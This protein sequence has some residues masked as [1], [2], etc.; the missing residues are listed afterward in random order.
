MAKNS[1]KISTDL[2]SA[3]DILTRLRAGCSGVRIPVGV[4]RFPLSK[5]V[6]TGSEAHPV[7]NL[8]GT[9]ILYWR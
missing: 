5:N 6:Q 2:Y 8:M 4:N 3:I 7:N 9:E 1:L